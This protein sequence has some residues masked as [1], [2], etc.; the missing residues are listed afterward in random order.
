MTR[1]RCSRLKETESHHCC[2][3]QALRCCVC[4]VTPHSAQP[5]TSPRLSLKTTGLSWWKPCHPLY[6]TYASEVRA[7]KAVACTSVS[8]LVGGSDR[9]CRRHIVEEMRCAL[10]IPPMPVPTCIP[11]NAR[12]IAPHASAKPLAA[13]PKIENITPPSP[14]PL[15]ESSG[16]PQLPQ[17]HCEA[18]SEGKVIGIH[19]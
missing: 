9:R 3:T 12:S 11:L 19:I 1:V 10:G 13:S 15:F 16:G 18:G 6:F 5:R 7:A 14:L 17:S 4:M 2:Y 8:L